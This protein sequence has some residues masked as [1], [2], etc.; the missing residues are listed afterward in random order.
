LIG[1]FSSRV[2][3]PRALP[4]ASMRWPPPKRRAL[5]LR[6]VVV[7]AVDAV[8][9][10]KR[11]ATR[12]LMARRSQSARSSGLLALASVE[13]VELA[14]RRPLLPAARLRNRAARKRAGRRP[15]HRQPGPKCRRRRGRSAGRENACQPAARR[16]WSARTTRAAAVLHSAGSAPENRVPPGSL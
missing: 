6:E 3:V 2:S 13:R 9:T 8:V 15:R 12:W 16:P 11:L 7:R 4:M 10:T 14:S 5:G 1:R